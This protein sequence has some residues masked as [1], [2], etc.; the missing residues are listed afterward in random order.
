MMPRRLLPLLVFAAAVALYVTSI[1]NGFAYDDH[2]VIR[3][4][5]RIQSLSRVSELF[6]R[7]YWSD[8]EL[9]LYRP[10]TSL[11]YAVD[12]FIS[13]GRPAWFHVVNVMWNAA[14][15]ALVVAFLFAFVPA[16][17][18]VLGGL[19]F[20][21]H[22]VH[23]EAVANIVGRAELM[24]AVFSLGALVLWVRSDPAAPLPR[25]RAFAIAG[26]YMLALLSKESAIMLPAV[27]A[28]ADAARGL[29]APGTWRAWL[30]RHA[31]ASAGLV[32]IAV[33]YLVVRAVVVGGVMPGRLD[34]ALAV[35]DGFAARIFTVLQAWPIILRLLV[36]P[37]TLLSDYG[38]RIIMPAT[39]LTPAAAAGALILVLLVAGGCAA[40][41]RGR[42]RAAA[43]LL[44]LPVTLLPTSNLIVPIGVI[45][46]ERT[47][48]LPSLAIVL[49]CAFALHPVWTA[50]RHRRAIVAAAAVVIVLFGARTLLRI[51]EWRSTDTVF[52][53][54]RRDRPDSFR[55]AWHHA[56]L[57]AGEQQ[58]A[59]AHAR[60]AR[61]IDLWP[62]RRN[63]LLE[64][65]AYAAQTGD[66]EFAERL[67]VFAGGLWP[68]D[69]DFLRMRAAAHLDRGELAAARDVID[70]A[71]R[72]APTD[73]T[74]L[75]MRA[76]AAG[77]AP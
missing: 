4:D 10:L 56:R 68:D 72:I 61:A 14:A 51:P 18:A 71:L 75:A 66:P 22:P 45:V 19:L 36:F 73:S 70:A 33:G 12:W 35:T 1:R 41:L 37:R 59:L 62:Y 30:Q 23:V 50:R 17:L 26:L 5:A 11:S 77:G 34:P 44:F 48:Y 55:A 27:L 49:L 16:G 31:R 28:L 58:P 40:W 7:P 69:V 13:G 3:A 64:A 8:P 43:V 54:L 9:G 42:G 29:L 52:A 63:L 15:A 39:T 20:A 76:A 32:A 47:L 65:A 46:A 2:M 74:L 6:T 25:R 57:A 53:A 21:A 38:P 24:A 67:V 60:Y